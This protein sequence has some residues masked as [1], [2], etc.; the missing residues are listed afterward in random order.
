[1]VDV[2]PEQTTGNRDRWII[3]W[4][5]AFAA[6]GY[7]LSVT[8]ANAMLP[9]IQGDLSASLDQ[10]SW[11]VTAA[12]VA[13]AL[14]IPPTPWM[15][16]RF[17][18][19]NVMLFALVVF[20]FSSTMLPFSQSL[21]DV[22]FW[23]VIQALSGAPI[24]VLSQTLTVSIFK[25]TQRSMAMAI[26]SVAL[27]TGWSFGPAIGAYI[28][29]LASWR[30]AFLTVSPISVLAVILCWYFLPRDKSDKALTFDWFGFG[31]LSAGLVALQIVINRGQREDWFASQE[32]VTL[33][34][35]GVA[36]L[37]I[38]TL[39]SL[40]SD[41]R[42]IRWTIFL[43]RNFAVAMLFTSVSGFTSLAPLVLVP[44][45]LEE[46]KGLELV[47]IG[48][49]VTPRAIV[50]IVFMLV[51]GRYVD[52]WDPRL[53]MGIGYSLYAVGS[54]LMSTYNMDIGMWD[55]LVPQILQGASSGMIWLPL[56]H[57]IYRTLEEEYRNEASMANMLFYNLISS[58]G[59]AVLLVILSRSVQINTEELGVHITATR[60]LLRYPQFSGFDFKSAT[61]AAAMHATIRQQAVMIGYVNIFWL[62]TWVALAAL[63]LLLLVPTKRS[64][65]EV[66][67]RQEQPKSCD[68]D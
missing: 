6:W 50:T 15:A 2:K 28:A 48:F 12:I 65:L 31:A 23:R 58:A 17:G 18:L 57:T 4:A 63:P 8:I 52:R 67:K 22:V 64:N 37:T 36:S 53:M 27:T 16:A 42:F 1:V 10:V 11:I 46:I 61:D 60:E 44:P 49:V 32:I 5:S 51:L 38:Y 68:L 45:M 25:G 33:T 14:G 62:L 20:T 40:T 21:S 3:F 13:G 56:F 43:D 39:H 19:K 34:A 54:W 35:I 9:Q 55:I 59:V 26:W 66:L 7:T 30:M 47:T 24:M 29:D 41:K